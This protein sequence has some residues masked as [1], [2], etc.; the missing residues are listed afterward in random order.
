MGTYYML[1]AYYI[2]LHYYSKYLLS[3]AVPSSSVVSIGLIIPAARVFS[4]GKEVCK[5]I[6]T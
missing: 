1:V 3:F 6:V 2:S 4:S 5:Q